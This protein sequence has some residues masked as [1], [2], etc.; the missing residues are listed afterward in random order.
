MA[1]ALSL[2]GLLVALALSACLEPGEF[3]YGDYLPE[4]PFEVFDRTEGIHP[5][6]AVLED[7]NNP[8]RLA[9]SG[10]DTRFQIQASGNPVASFYSW[11]TWLVNEP[12]G[13]AQ[14]F[15]AL[16]LAEI[17][18]TGLAVQR[19][20]ETVRQMAVEA[21][22]TVLEEFPDA[23]TFDVTGTIRYEL[24]TPAYQAIVELGGTPPAGWVLVEDANG[25][26]RAVRQ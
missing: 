4:G 22:T 9:S 1:R 10:K 11:A 16:N 17:W 14:Y 6:E 18:R 15:A 13:E 26:V 5:S 12:T 8:F 23:A 7:P 25:I 3:V 21:Y 2:L 20:L 19:D 24:V